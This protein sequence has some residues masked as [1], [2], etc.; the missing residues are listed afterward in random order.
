M[1]GVKEGTSTILR[2]DRKLSPIH[3]KNLVT[4][5]DL[6][7][8]STYNAELRGICNYY[9]MAVDFQK[10]NY[11]AYLMEYSCL[12]TLASKHKSKI[13]K[14]V[15]MFSDGHGGWGIPYETKVGKKRCY[16]AKYTE[17]R[18]TLNPNDIINNPGLWYGTAINS[19]ENRLKAKICEQ[20][21]TTAAENYEVHHVNKLKNLKG[22]TAWERSM[23][24]KRRKTIV[25][26]RACHMNIHYPKKIV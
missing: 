20:C 21:G 11:F 14:I 26:C 25:V 7:I 5:T 17:C 16:F 4:L 8:V 18:K 22:K 24:A 2:H 6:E 1:A 19:F 12:K 9:N 10:L 3:R 15:K 23:I 13:N